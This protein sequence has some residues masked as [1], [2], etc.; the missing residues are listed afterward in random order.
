MKKAIVTGASGFVGSALVKLLSAK[1]IETIAVVRSEASVLEH[2]RNLPNVSIYFC[3][4]EHIT[5]LMRQI[6]DRDF[7]VFFH[8]AWEGTARSLRLATK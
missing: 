6:L 8:F 5:D 1:G 3:D 2:I 4:M 7:D